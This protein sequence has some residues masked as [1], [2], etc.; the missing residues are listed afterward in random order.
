M[1]SNEL[2]LLEYIFGVL[3]NTLECLK[4][5]TFTLTQV[6]KCCEK[7]VLLLRYC[8]SVGDTPLVTLS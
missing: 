6:K 4:M 2:H 7:T 8:G 5:G 1:G 3:T